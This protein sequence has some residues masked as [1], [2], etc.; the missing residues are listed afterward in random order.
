MVCVVWGLFVSFGLV[1]VLS[2]SLSICL[3]VVSIAVHFCL[4]VFVVAF[5]SSL[6]F[7]VD[8]CSCYTYP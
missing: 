5:L 6:R 1:F 8:L 2:F 3:F 4:C 7:A